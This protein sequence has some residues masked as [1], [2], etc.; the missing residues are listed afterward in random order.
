MTTSSNPDEIRAE[1][2]RTRN[3]L[4]TNVDTL[5]YEANPK[6][7][8]KRKVESVT[9]RFGGLRDRVM[10]SAH[11]TLDSSLETV[12]DTQD[13][14]VSAVQ[15]APGAAKRTTQGNPWGA[16]LVAFG[17][18]LAVAAA[19]PATQKEQDAAV[20]VKDKAQPL[21]QEL[22][23]VAK[24]TAANLQEPAQQAAQTVK[25]AAT[26][27]AGTVQ[28]ETTSAAQDVHGSAMDAKDTVQ[29]H[30]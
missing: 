14:A 4:S 8:A 10:G 1:I 3:A 16:G 2:E 29:Q 12:S 25:D 5:A 11:D 22:T 30:S 6:T 9:G 7:M 18:G 21:Q 24:D 17:V 15:G 28:D 27:A 19:F 26:D 23:Q 13:A 20:A